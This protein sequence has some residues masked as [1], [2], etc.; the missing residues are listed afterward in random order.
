MI[1]F[2]KYVNKELFVRKKMTNFIEKLFK[3]LGYSFDHDRYKNILYSEDN[4]R[5]Q[6]EEKVKNS[7]DAY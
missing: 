6:M 7:Y 5:N 1:D 2:S 4:V 3:F